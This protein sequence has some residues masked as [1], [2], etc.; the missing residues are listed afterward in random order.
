MADPCGKRR[1]FEGNLR[2]TCS[3]KLMS[4]KKNVFPAAPSVARRKELN[5]AF[6]EFGDAPQ[7]VSPRRS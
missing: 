4:N 6:N 3:I 7:P 2:G 5:R 1:Y